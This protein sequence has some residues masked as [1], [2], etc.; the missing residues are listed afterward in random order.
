MKIFKF[1]NG[2]KILRLASDIDITGEILINIKEN[3]CP[4]TR[5]FCKCKTEGI[6]CLINEDCKI[7]D[8]KGK[9]Y[10]KKNACHNFKYFINLKQKY[11]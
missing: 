3:Q 1:K 11:K 6:Y 4:K 7:V 10:P 5:E 2:K 9:I 8:A